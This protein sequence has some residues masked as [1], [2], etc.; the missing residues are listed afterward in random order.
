MLCI[1]GA[2]FSVKA[3]LKS[4]QVKVK[5]NRAVWPWVKSSLVPWPC[6]DS[7]EVKSWHFSPAMHP[8]HTWPFGGVSQF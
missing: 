8:R 5:T 1:E 7:A 3:H 2:I 6:R 4:Q